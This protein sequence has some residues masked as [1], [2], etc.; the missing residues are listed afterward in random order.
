M[1][2]LLIHESDFPDV[3]DDPVVKS[4][5]LSHFNEEID[6]DSDPGLVVKNQG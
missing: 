2:F 5:K 1:D 4:Q 3:F 6:Y